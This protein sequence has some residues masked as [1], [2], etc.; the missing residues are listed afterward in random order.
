MSH[1]IP[2]HDEL[3]EAIATAAGR[4]FRDLFAQ[5]PGHFYYVSLITTGEAHAPVIAAWSE[6]SLAAVASSSHDPHDALHYLK[7]SY[8][9]SPFYCYGEQY[10]DRVNQLFAD[11]PD[12]HSLEDAARDIEYAARLNAMESAMQR[13]D[14]QG[15]FGEG[16]RRHQIVIHVEVMPPDYT[17]TLRALRLNPPESL[18]AWLAEAAE[19]L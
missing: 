6:E 18:S 1:S 16:V 2:S 8:A 7:W 19:P 5:H 3:V 9:E 10:F 12:I 17:N 11:R 4:A 15:L 13:L 14:A